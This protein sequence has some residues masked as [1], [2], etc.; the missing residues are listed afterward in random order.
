MNKTILLK[1]L[2][3]SLVAAVAM[4]SISSTAEPYDYTTKTINVYDHS[5]NLINSFIAPDVQYIEVQDSNLEPEVF[6]AGNVSFTMIPV[7]GTGIYN[8]SFNNHEVDITTVIPTFYI[9]ETEVTNALWNAVMGSIPSTGSHGDQY[10]VTDITWSEICSSGGFLDQLNS[11]LKEQL[12]GRKF[13]LPGEWEWEYAANGG[14]RLDHYTFAGSNTIGDVAWYKDNSSDE[15]KEVKGKK[16]NGLGI[17][18][19]SGN[20]WELCSDILCI[21]ENMDERPNEAVCRGG[22]FLSSATFNAIGRRSNCDIDTSKNNI[23]FRIVL[24]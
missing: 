4:N 19:M 13:C 6:T 23:G 14:N 3:L 5:N 10:P 17:Y 2:T 1:S 7:I 16:P 18:D 22:S 21:D 8:N 20:V 24:K 11:K 12:N 15:I 9:G